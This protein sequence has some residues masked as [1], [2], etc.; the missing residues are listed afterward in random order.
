MRDILVPLAFTLSLLVP[1]YFALA[2]LGTRFALWDYKFGLGVLTFK[3]GPQVLMGAAGLGALALIVALIASPDKG[4]TTGHPHFAALVALAIPVAGLLFASYV[5]DAQKLIPPIHDIS[6][7]WQDPPDFSDAIMKQ[8]GMMSNPLPHPWETF[9]EN[10]RYPDLTGK[11]YAE[12]QKWAYSDISPILLDVAPDK[13][14]VAALKAARKLGL[15]IVAAEAAIGRVEGV[16]TTFWF[17]FKDDLVVRVRAKGELG[18]VVDVR[19]VSRV[20][21]SD[22]GT[23]A[24]RIRALREAL[25]ASV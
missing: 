10:P 6:T 20:G 4:A 22:L 17:G 3:F 14:F 12:V 18:S 24:K 7:D 23:N 16:A 13:A 9:P 1:A 8:R 5:R 11:S 21:V 15:E 25:L 2:A 19:S